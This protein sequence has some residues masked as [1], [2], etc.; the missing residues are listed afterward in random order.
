M[1]KNTSTELLGLKLTK[2]SFGLA[3]EKAVG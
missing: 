1:K 2:E 3:V